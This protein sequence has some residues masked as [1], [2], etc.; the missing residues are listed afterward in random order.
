M[1]KE[2]LKKRCDILLLSMV[3]K[4]LVERWWNG[5]NKA[6]NQTPQKQFD[7]NPQLVYNYLIRSS[8]GDW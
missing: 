4:D 1:D 8:E 6:F 3:G 5:Y 7:E 2:L